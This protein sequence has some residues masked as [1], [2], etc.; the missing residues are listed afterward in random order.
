MSVPKILM[1]TWKTREVPIGW[2]PSPKSIQQH[3]PHWK[4]ILNTDEDN[5]NF[6]AQHFP[7]FLPTYDGFQ[8]PIQR[9]DAIRYMWLYVHGGLYM[10]LDIELMKDLT[11]LFEGKSPS[12]NSEDCLYLVRSPDCNAVSQTVTNAIMASTPRNPFWLA[13]IEEMKRDVPWYIQIEHHYYIL[14]ST[15]SLLVSRMVEKYQP[16]YVILPKAVFPY[17]VC[18]KAFNDPDAWIKPLPG[19]SWTQGYWDLALYAY[20]HTYMVSFIVILVVFLVLGLIVAGIV[21]RR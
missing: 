6:V 12:S 16:T 3:M 9:A 19:N 7:E 17:S 13:V 10:D 5:R 15:G 20:C 8:Y 1:Q 4:Y 21:E 2:Q 14:Y 18:A 11:P